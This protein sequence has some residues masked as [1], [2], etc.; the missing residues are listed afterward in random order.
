MVGPLWLAAWVRPLEFVEIAVTAQNQ[1]AKQEREESRAFSARPYRR[2]ENVR[3]HPVVVAELEFIDVEREI[4]PA[5]LMERSHDAALN[6]R[7]EAFDG[8]GVNV[9]V[10]IFAFAVVHHAMRE[11]LVQIPIASVVVGGN[12]AHPVRYGFR[13]KTVKSFSICAFTY[14][15]NHV[16]FTPPTPAYDCF[17][18]PACPAHV[19]TSA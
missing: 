1:L 3:V 19:A 8:V 2:S 15:G 12:Q 14:A 5:D 18:M 11:V 9:S 16:S 6:Q 7:P 17:P 13:D 4:F 10:H